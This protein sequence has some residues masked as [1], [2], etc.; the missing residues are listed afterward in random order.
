MLKDTDTVY[1]VVNSPSAFLLP[2]SVSI[3]ETVSGAQF[4]TQGIFQMLVW[5]PLFQ[6][7]ESESPP[8][9]VFMARNE[10]CVCSVDSY[11]RCGKHTLQ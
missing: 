5:H 2:L 10:A 1:S 7:Q 11:F 4:T 3:A 6:K 8:Q 9:V